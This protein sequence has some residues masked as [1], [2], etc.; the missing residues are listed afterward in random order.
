M[1]PRD[2]NLNRGVSAKEYSVCYSVLLSGIQYYTVLCF[3]RF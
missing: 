2:G 3:Q 1:L